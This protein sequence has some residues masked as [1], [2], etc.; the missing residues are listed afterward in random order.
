M[1]RFVWLGT[2]L[3]LPHIRV[4]YQIYH[5]IITKLINPYLNIFEWKSDKYQL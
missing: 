3:Y 5:Q 4:K 1:A 2:Q